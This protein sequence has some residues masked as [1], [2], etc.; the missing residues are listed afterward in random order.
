MPNIYGRYNPE[1]QQFEPNTNAA[2]AAGSNPLPPVNDPEKTFADITKQEYMDYLENF[3]DFEKELVERATTD[4]S[5]IDY[6]RE[7]AAG[8]AER[9]RAVAERNRSRYGIALTPA[10]VAERERSVNRGSVLGGVQSIA[11]ARIAQRDQNQKLLNDLMA[12]G[13]GINRN[14]LAQLG[15]AAADATSRNNAYRSAQAASKQA[16]YSAIGGLGSMAIMALML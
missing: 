6:A 7:D 13:Q 11:D 16:T 10:E 4:T 5:L 14:S 15:S 3:R 12:I 1:T 2:G 8:A 9:T